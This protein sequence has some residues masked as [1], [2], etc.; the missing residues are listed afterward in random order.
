MDEIGLKTIEEVGIGGEYLTHQK[1]LEHCRTEFFLTN[2][3]NRLP[4]E[5]WTESGKMRL[6]ENAQVMVNERISSY[7]Q[8]SIDPDIEKALSLYVT[9]RENQ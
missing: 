6:E 9:K 4:Y 7:Q 5:S 8:P 2:L 3:M 1:T